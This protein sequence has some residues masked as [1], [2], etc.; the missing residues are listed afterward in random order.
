MEK[1]GSPSLALPY[2]H[3][4]GRQKKPGFSP[5]SSP[6]VVPIDIAT[7]EQASSQVLLSP[8]HR[9]LRTEDAETP[10][11]GEDRRQAWD[12]TSP[13]LFSS[14]ALTNHCSFDQQI[15]SEFILYASDMRRIT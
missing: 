12:Q 9:R 14:P 5:C 11:S 10:N 8:S 2:G 3:R 13:T 6:D 7:P 4:H 15:F 1:G